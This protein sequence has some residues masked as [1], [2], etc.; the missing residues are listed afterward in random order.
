[1]TFFADVRVLERREW[2]LAAQKRCPSL[3]NV[4]EN[5]PSGI[6]NTRLEANSAGW[7]P[8]CGD[9]ADAEVIWL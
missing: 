4:R 5:G 7:R 9:V 6:E 3:N 8:L 1:L 2:V